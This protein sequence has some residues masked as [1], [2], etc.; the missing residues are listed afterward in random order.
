MVVVKKKW[1]LSEFFE[2]NRK[3]AKTRFWGRFEQQ[4]QNRV[5]QDHQVPYAFVGQKVVKVVKIDQKPFFR[6]I[7]II[8]SFFRSRPLS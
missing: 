7:Q 3:V 5:F 1:K 8:S 4:T 6:N 2:K